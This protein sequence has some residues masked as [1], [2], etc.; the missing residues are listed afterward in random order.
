MR[1]P[2]V[3][4]QER[5]LVICFV[6]GDDVREQARVSRDRLTHIHQTAL[7]PLRQRR[8]EVE[9]NS[10][11]VDSAVVALRRPA[12][13][14]HCRLKVPGRI[15][16]APAASREREVEK[17]DWAAFSQFDRAPNRGAKLLWATG[18]EHAVLVC[19]ICPS[20]GVVG[21]RAGGVEDL[22]IRYACYRGLAGQKP[23]VPIE[24]VGGIFG[25]R[26]PEPRPLGKLLQS[27]FPQL[28][29]EVFARLR[30]KHSRGST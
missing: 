12:T 27:E 1:Q 5:L 28:A 17:P 16:P 26:A 29:R 6:G 25:S 30:F 23:L 4:L 21:D 22:D 14:V 7:R 11:V 9:A 20:A 3:L 18:D 19:G 13:V 15:T 24:H 2:Q 10:F 8:K